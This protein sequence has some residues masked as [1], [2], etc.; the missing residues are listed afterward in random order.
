MSTVQFANHISVYGTETYKYTLSKLLEST[1]ETELWNAWKVIINTDYIS[2]KL[3]KT[4][5][6]GKYMLRICF[7][8]IYL[9]FNISRPLYDITLLPPLC[10]LPI[11]SR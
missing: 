2:R 8:S 1:R 6:Y 4:Y 9:N 5:I 11:P 7:I 10:Y 3:V